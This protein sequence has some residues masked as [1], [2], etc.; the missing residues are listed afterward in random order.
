MLLLISCFISGYILVSAPD[1]TAVTLTSFAQADSLIT[2]EL[3]NFNI[4]PAQIRTEAVFTDTTFARKIYYVD[5]PDYLSKTQ[6]H[7]ELNQ[8]FYDYSIKT[9]A[10]IVFPEENMNIHL[11]YEGTVIRTIS[12]KT[13]DS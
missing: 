10:Q 12:L 11:L 7:A 4:Q 5:V 3:S 6:I 1:R 9:P 13:N 2:Q 8:V